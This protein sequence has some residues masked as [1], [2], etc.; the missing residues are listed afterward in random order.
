MKIYLDNSDWLKSGTL[1]DLSTVLLLSAKLIA[2]KWYEIVSGRY[3]S[4]AGI[5]I[6]HILL[7]SVTLYV[8]CSYIAGQ[9]LWLSLKKCSCSEWELSHEPL[10]LKRILNSECQPP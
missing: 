6:T 3:E 9:I 10:Q 5:N 7:H 1:H 2:V 4:R 8:H